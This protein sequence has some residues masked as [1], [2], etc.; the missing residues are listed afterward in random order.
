MTSDQDRYQTILANTH[1]AGVY[2]MPRIDPQPLIDAAQANGQAVFRIDLSGAQDKAEMLGIVAKGMAYPD[3][4]GHNFDALADMV[5]DLGWRP[6]EGYLVLLEKCDGI[7]GR[8]E[9]DFVNM[10]QIFEQ[11]AAEWREANVPLW[12][13][14]DM[15]A[16]GINWLPDVP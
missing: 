11:A 14:V 9:R 3:L 12:C 2:H 1:R 15:Q 8:A 4:F 6:A 13:F 10:L 5:N 7:H 16:D